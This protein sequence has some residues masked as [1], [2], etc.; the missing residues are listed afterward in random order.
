LYYKKLA[1]TF[2]ERFESR[3]KYNENAHVFD[4]LSLAAPNLHKFI[5]S[6]KGQGGEGVSVR[7]LSSEITE[8]EEM[9]VVLLLQ[10][11]KE[12]EDKTIEYN[13]GTLVLENLG[14]DWK[15][16]GWFWRAS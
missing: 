16:T 15:V 4:A 1:R 5:E 9:K 14:D 6:S 10:I 2:V 3:S 13:E 11:Q 7:V 12:F 8:K